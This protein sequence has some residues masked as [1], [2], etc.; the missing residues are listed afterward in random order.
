G[1]VEPK[2]LDPHWN[3]DTRKDAP[4]LE[5]AVERVADASNPEH[6]IE[7]EKLDHFIYKGLKGELA[8][9]EAVRAKGGWATI[10]GG[11]IA[12]GKS[13]PRIA[14]VRARLASTGELASA[15][16]ADSS[17][18]DDSLQSAIRL[19]QDRHRLNS[20][21]TIDKAT[22]AALNVPVEQR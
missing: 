22:L 15:Q 3:V 17:V 12:P 20:S 19:F 6:A 14:L 11:P 4:P 18:Y 21:R 9:L 13:D 7:K 5:A 16:A 8:R 2:S 1:R 10:P